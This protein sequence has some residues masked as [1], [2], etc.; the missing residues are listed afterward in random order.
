MASPER[1]KYR[2]EWA[3][4][5]YAK[6]PERYR[7]ARAK[8][9]ANETD[10]QRTKRREY[11][12]R[13]REKNRERLKEQNRKYRESN[14]RKARDNNLRRTGW[15]SAAFEAALAQQKGLC[16]IC[17][18][19]LT[20]LPRK[21]VHADHCHTENKPRGILCHACN[22]GIGLLKEDLKVLVAAIKYIKKWR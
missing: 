5:A 8:S 1:K 6:D 14:P 21:H 16:A 18:A 17:D 4:A 9:Y 10:E 22:S 7:E 12:K 2:R 19:D 15:T 13:Y 3:K 20:R 11:A